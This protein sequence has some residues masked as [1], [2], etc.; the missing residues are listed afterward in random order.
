MAAP[1]EVAL[2]SEPVVVRG[3]LVRIPADSCIWW[4]V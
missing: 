4:A 3:G 1:G 2:S